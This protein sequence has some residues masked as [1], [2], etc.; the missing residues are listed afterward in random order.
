M[1][2]VMNMVL[3]YISKPED[4]SKTYTVVMAWVW[5]IGLHSISHYDSWFHIIFYYILVSISLLK[6]QPNLSTLVTYKR[7]SS[8]LLFGSSVWKQMSYIIL[9]SYNTFVVCFWVLQLLW[10]YIFTFNGL[11]MMLQGILNKNW[12]PSF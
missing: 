1:S 9:L 3:F 8:I 4:I 2:D 11:P 12:N 5:D 6:K 7:K 10:Y